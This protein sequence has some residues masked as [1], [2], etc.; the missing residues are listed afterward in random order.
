MACLGGL[1]WFKGQDV[2]VAAMAAVSP[3]QARLTL[4]GAVNN[5]EYLRR[6]MDSAPPGALVTHAG[7]YERPDLP[8][9]LSRAD[10]VVVPSRMETFSFVAREALHAG[11]PVLAARAGALPEAV[12]HGVDGLLF[13]VGDAA[14]LGAML[15]QLAERPQDLERLARGIGPVPDADADADFWEA[16][17]AKAASGA[18]GS[19][20]SRTRRPWSGAGAG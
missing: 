4:H 8:R 1:C 13:P 2:A 3:E 11:V 12:R 15:R 16:A 5:P 20:A 6:V 18:W 7:G 9:I 17:Y 19:G 10:C 14:A